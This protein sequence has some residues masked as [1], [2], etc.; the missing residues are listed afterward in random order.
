MSFDIFLQDFSPDSVDRTN[1]VLKALGPYLDS[2]KQNVITTDGDA[3]VYGV[4]S[5]PIHDLMFNHVAGDVMWQ[6]IY[7]TA[8]AAEWVI[9][10]GDGGL[11]MV[12]E[13]QRAS[14]PTEV[15][16]EPFALVTSGAELKEALTG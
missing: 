9:M 8:V 10:S 1:E 12:V 15:A 4:D 5:T 7:E 3:A 13:S 6:L 11:C 2:S 14:V 16:W